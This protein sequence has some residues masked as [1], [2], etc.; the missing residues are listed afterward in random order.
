VIH[1]WWRALTLGS[2]VCALAA[3]PDAYAQ[4]AV[5]PSPVPHHLSVS[6]GLFWSGGYDIGDATAQ[7][8]G[9]A[10]GATAPPFTLFRA[11]SSVAATAGLDGRVGFAITRRLMVEFGMSYQRPGITTALSQDAEA[12]AVAI[13]AER[14]SQYV[15]DAG[16]LWQLSRIRLGARARPFV[17][18]GG[19]YVRQL[20]DDRTLV[21]HGSVYYAGGGLRYWLRGGDGQ[22]HAA[23]LRADGRLQWRIDGVEFEGRTRVMPALTVHAFFEF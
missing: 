6:A 13:D 22:R 7:L 9:N 23:G 20:Y 16:A 17:L 11:E 15:F 18:A 3:A 4:P 21:E 2:A 19:G 10:V 1:R 8:R 5:S 12:T 14:L